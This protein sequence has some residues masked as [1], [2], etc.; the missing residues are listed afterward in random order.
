MGTIFSLPSVVFLSA[1][2]TAMKNSK[3]GIA[4]FSEIDIVRHGFAVQ[5]VLMLRM[6]ASSGGFFIY[7]PNVI[8]W[9]LIIDG[10][11]RP[12]FLRRYLVWDSMHCSDVALDKK[13]PVTLCVSYQIT[14]L[15]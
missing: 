7:L 8:M 9:H 2:G 15:K 4:F 10:L 6:G 3:G 5:N 11:Q 12:E 14:K 1:Y 13:L